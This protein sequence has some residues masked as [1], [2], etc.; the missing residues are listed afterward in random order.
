M[1]RSLPLFDEPSASGFDRARLA[2]SLRELARHDILIG[3]SSWKYEGWLGQIYTPEAYTV[4]GRFSKKRFEQNC[5]REYAEVFPAVCGDFSFYQFPAPDFWEKLF[6]TAPPHLQFAFKV[7][8][9]ITCRT[10]PSHARYGPRAGMANDNFLN[11]DMFDALFTDLL[12]PWRSRIPVLIFEFGTFPKRSYEAPDEFFADLNAFLARLP[13]G[14]RYS[15]EIRNQEF[16]LPG[17]FQTLRQH[18]VAH[19]FNA[20]TRMPPIH[21]QM[22]I[23]DAFTA[24]FTVA[25]ALLR[26]G[27][28]YEN[29]VSTFSPYDQVQEVNPETRDSLRAMVELA[30]QRRQ[31]AYLFINNRLEGNAPVTIDA[32]VHGGMSQEA[33]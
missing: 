6:T 17:Y 32:V 5:I 12:T 33:R 14:W 20:W 16:L 30:R 23:P 9:E 28:S 18:G 25:R 29:A 15:V 10:F 22:D 13:Q 19:T 31:A 7:P 4:R 21:C 27:R 11:A 24:D 8:E 26:T 1:A 2:A 3:T